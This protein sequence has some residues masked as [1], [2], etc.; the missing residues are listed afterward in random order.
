VGSGAAALVEAGISTDIVS[1]CV[2]DA[3]RAGRFYVFTHPEQMG[4][5]KKRADAIL[6]AGTAAEE[7]I[8]GFR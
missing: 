7:V 5:V 4:A 2:V 8:A 1:H 3:L 6:R